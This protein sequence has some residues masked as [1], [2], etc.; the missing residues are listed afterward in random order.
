MVYRDPKNWRD[1]RYWWWW[2]RFGLGAEAKFG[3]AIGAAVGLVVAG[4]ITADTLSSEEDS[5]T[6]TLPVDTLA[7]AAVS[8]EPLEQAD[9]TGPAPGTGT[10]SEVVTVF[11]TVTRPGETNF[12]TV[13]RNGRTLDVRKVGPGET[14]TYPVTVPGPVRE[15]VLTNERTQTVVRTERAE[16]PTTVTTPGTTKTVTREVTQPARATTVTTPGTTQTVTREVTQPARTVT[17]TNAVTV[18]QPVTVTQEVT[19]TETVK[20]KPPPPPQP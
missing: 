13:R 15:R 4:V 16:R 20:G 8:E 7:D 12:E 1:P 6:L 5:Q 2:W 14:V 10:V 3:L 17:E 9:V 11:V 18:T 19:V